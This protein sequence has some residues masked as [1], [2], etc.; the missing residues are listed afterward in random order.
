MNANEKWMNSA[1]CWNGLL[2][3]RMKLLHQCAIVVCIRSIPGSTLR[4]SYLSRRGV[5]TRKTTN[6]PAKPHPTCYA[7]IFILT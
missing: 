6:I 1:G 5:R 2:F 3:G 4:V 7:N